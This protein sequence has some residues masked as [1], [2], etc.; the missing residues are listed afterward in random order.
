MQLSEKSGNVPRALAKKF[1]FERK[2]IFQAKERGLVSIQNN[3]FLFDD[4]GN[5]R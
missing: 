3:S 4:D 1:I 5:R 2:K